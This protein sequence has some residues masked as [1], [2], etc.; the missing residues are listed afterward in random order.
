MGR[1][2]TL[3][4]SELNKDDS[5]RSLVMEQLAKDMSVA[6]MVKRIPA[7]TKLRLYTRLENQ[8]N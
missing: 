8:K 3:I 5:L 2:W 4:I 1:L 7:L 6:K